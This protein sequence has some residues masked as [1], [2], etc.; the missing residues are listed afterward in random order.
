MSIE[1]LQMT[2]QALAFISAVLT[3]RAIVSSSW[4]M[5]WAGAIVSL[6]FSLAALWSIAPL[7][8]LATCLQLAAA[9]GLRWSAGVGVWLMLAVGGVATFGVLVYGIGL[10]RGETLWPI[11]LPL[12]FALWSLPLLKR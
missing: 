6:V 4:L 1:A 3:L 11:A 8:Y 7:M 10:T 9:F 12:A 5:M 2:L